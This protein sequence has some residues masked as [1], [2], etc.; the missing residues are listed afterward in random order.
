MTLVDFGMKMRHKMEHCFLPNC[1]QAAS[2]QD[3][4]PTSGYS[5]VME[6]FG[7]PRMTL[8]CFLKVPK[9]DQKLRETLT[10]LIM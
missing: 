5:W 3:Q 1:V 10:K 8:Q 7:M 4:V 9:E 6:R 2:F